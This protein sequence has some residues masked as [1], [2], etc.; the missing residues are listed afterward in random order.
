MGISIEDLGITQE[1][2]QARVVDQLC[3]E[4]TGRYDDES[5]YSYFS[6]NSIKAKMREYLKEIVDKKIREVVDEKVLANFEKYL[7]ELIIK[8]ASRWGEKEGSPVSIEDYI[9]KTISLTLAEEVDDQGRERDSSSYSYYSSTRPRLKYLIERK[10]S[11]EIKASFDSVLVDV[12]AS[13]QS[14]I[15]EMVKSKLNKTDISFDVR[16]YVHN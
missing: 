4:I 7:Q 9:E 3:H 11:A 6:E 1:E 10:I 2:L 16:G 8:P 14:H 5:E 15:E 13:L 12:K